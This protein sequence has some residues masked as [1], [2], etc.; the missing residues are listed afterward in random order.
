MAR[1]RRLVLT[2]IPYLITQHRNPIG[3]PSSRRQTLYLDLLAQSAGKAGG[4]I[5]RYGLMPT[6]AQTVPVCGEE[7]GLMRMKASSAS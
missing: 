3:R 4:A 6:H 5:W 2:G 1:L 7:D